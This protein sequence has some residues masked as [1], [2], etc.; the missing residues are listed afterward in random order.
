VLQGCTFLAVLM[1]ETFRDRDFGAW[2]AVRM[3]R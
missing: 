3:G 1:A 2:F